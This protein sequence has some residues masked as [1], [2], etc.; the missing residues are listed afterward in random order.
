MAPKDSKSKRKIGIFAI[1]YLV[2]NILFFL[3]EPQLSSP[4][5]YRDRHPAPVSI[6]SPTDSSMSLDQI[7]RILNEI[8]WAYQ[9]RKPT[10][11]E[12]A[13]QWSLAAVALLFFPASIATASKSFIEYMGPANQQ[14]Q[15][16]TLSVKRRYNH[17]VKLGKMKGMTQAGFLFKEEPSLS[18]L[19]ADPY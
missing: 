2:V 11:R 19:N 6:E 5:H 1:F 15:A 8:D 18:K 3:A 14:Q 9:A 12:K 16:F 4:W 7:V 17:L 13:K 10:T